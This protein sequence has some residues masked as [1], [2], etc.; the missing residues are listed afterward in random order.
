[1][2]VV[3][4]LKNDVILLLNN[5]S[6]KECINFCLNDCECVVVLYLLSVGECM[7]YD[8][9]RWVKR[10]DGGSGLSYLVKV[11][12]GIINGNYKKIG[13]RKWVLILIVRV[14]DLIFLLVVG[15]IVYFMIWK[16]EKERKEEGRG[17]GW[18]KGGKKMKK[19]IRRE[20]R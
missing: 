12:K 6:I 15:G 2:N 8:M 14:D 10:I 20:R 5:M 19:N 4:L 16:R 11:L 7:F 18:E 13:L 1:M 3:I 17:E 9:V